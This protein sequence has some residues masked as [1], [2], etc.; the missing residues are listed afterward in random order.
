VTTALPNS[1][2]QQL[3]SVLHFFGRY[4][5]LLADTERTA[6]SFHVCLCGQLQVRALQRAFLGSVDESL[7]SLGDGRPPDSNIPSPA[8]RLKQLDLCIHSHICEGR[9]EG[10]GRSI[11]ASKKRLG[12]FRSR[13]KRADTLF[14]EAQAAYRQWQDVHDMPDSTEAMARFDNLCNAVR[15]ALTPHPWS[16]IARLTLGIFILAA[17]GVAVAI[18]VPMLPLFLPHMVSSMLDSAPH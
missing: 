13:V 9:L 17:L 16:R 12:R 3:G 10:L 6:I 15:V 18:I 7:R 11:T 1:A 8:D 14:Q 5:Q 4:Q 2:A